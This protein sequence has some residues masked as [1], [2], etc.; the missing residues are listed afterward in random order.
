[1]SPAIEQG[2]PLDSSGSAQPVVGSSPNPDTKPNIEV[3]K[4]PVDDK[5]VLQNESVQ[6]SAPVAEDFQPSMVPEIQP[7]V[8]I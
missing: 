1:M 7:K 5:Q 8:P 6:I 2:S 4:P 3:V